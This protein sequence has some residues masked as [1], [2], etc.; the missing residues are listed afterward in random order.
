MRARRQ[1]IVM[2]TLTFSALVGCRRE[3]AAPSADTA[4]QAEAAP[5]TT[6]SNSSPSSQPEETQLRTDFA[7]SA[8]GGAAARAAAVNVPF[9]PYTT[10]A[11]LVQFA[12]EPPAVVRAA[13]VAAADVFLAEQVPDFAIKD[14]ERPWLDRR[15]EPTAFRVHRASDGTWSAEAVLRLTEWDEG[16]RQPPREIALQLRWD[17]AG[18]RAESLPPDYLRDMEFALDTLNHEWRPGERAL[19]DAP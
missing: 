16:R 7:C 9:F 3:S 4:P 11:D 8:F 2:L 10:A 17:G 14:F 19:D 13:M 15:Y 12:A 6:V 5:K 1:L 18:W